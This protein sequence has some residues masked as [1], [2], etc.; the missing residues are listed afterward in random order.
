LRIL[1]F[2]QFSLHY[3]IKKNKSASA[4]TVI[5]KKYLMNSHY[6]FKAAKKEQPAKA[7]CFSGS[8]QLLSCKS[9]RN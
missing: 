5:I 6:S 8:L 2:N 9:I 7:G 4:L 3:I 1:S